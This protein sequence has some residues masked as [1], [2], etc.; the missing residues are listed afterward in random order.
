M[1]KSE[2]LTVE[3]H[4]HVTQCYQVDVNLFHN[5]VLFNVLSTNKQVLILFLYKNPSRYQEKSKCQAEVKN[6]VLLIENKMQND[7]FRGGSLIVSQRQECCARKTKC[8]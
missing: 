5:I 7:F 2:A 1:P 8:Q 3:E 4:T 6:L